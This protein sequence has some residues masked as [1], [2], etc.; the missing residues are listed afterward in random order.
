MDDRNI[1]IKPEES[2]TAEVTHLNGLLLD[3]R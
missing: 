2:T 1:S 3:N